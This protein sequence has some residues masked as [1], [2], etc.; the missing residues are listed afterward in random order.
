MVRE[1]PPER[2]YRKA[3]VAVL[4]DV[5]SASLAEQRAR[6]QQALLT[7]FQRS[8][9]RSL[10]KDEPLEKLLSR[11]LPLGVLTDIVAFTLKFDVSFK[12]KL[13]SEWNVDSRAKLLL[14]RLSAAETDE[15]GAQLAFPP[16]FSDN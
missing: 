8:L 3:E 10:A 12:Q 15:P 13:L 5:Y 4:E 2:V 1:L 16:R 11:E 14:E 9:R 6:T 7:A